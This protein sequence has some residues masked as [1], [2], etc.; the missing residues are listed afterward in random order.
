MSVWLLAQWPAFVSGFLLCVFLLFGG[1]LVAR[2][3]LLAKLD[4]WFHD[5]D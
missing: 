4:H 3:W 5:D 1:G 2:A